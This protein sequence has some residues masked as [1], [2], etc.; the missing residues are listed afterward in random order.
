MVVTTLRARLLNGCGTAK[1][2]V[3]HVMDNGI[4]HP[5]MH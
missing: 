4:E 3:D 1:G 2:F 5:A